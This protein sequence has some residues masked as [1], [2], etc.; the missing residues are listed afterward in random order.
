MNGRIV[1]LIWVIA[2]GLTLAA[3]VAWRASS[4]APSAASSALVHATPI[5]VD[6]VDRVEIRRPGPSR[7]SAPIEVVFERSDEGWRQ[8]EPFEVTADGFAVRRVVLAAA[9]LSATRRN[10]VGDLADGGGLER[11]ELATPD[12]NVTLT[13]PGGRTSIDLGA[14]TV[15]GRA[16]IRIDDRDEVLVVNDALH[17]QAVEDDPRN[18]RSRR[19][20]PGNAEITEFRSANGDS[21]TRL[22][23]D[24]R[25]WLM[26]SPAETRADAAAIDRLVAIVGR[27]EHDGFVTDVPKQLSRYG[28][29][30]PAAIIDVVRDDGQVE[31]LLIGGPAGLVGRGRFAMIDGVPTVF[32]IDEST[33]RGLLPAV[34]SFIDSTGTGVDVA[35]V[36]YL[37][38]DTEQGRVRLDRDLDRWTLSV[39]D[40]PSGPVSGARVEALLAILSSTAAT[41]LQIQAFP[42]R[43]QVGTIVL[44]A[45]DGRPLDAIRIARESA[46]GRWATENGDGVLRL[47]PASTIM[48]LT[49]SAWINAPR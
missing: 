48:P 34:V 37:V 7:E 31:R 6:D 29:E 20:F 18:W 3:R 14:R 39:D 38:I 47:L 28:L 32:R 17:E 24:G 43:L 9:D 1:L 45:F 11:V 2:I 33:L 41:E 10:Q 44:H 25:R 16:W 36:R 15:A 21:V 5:P 23:R 30:D 42:A 19:L 27:I 35:D 49:P 4:E 46:D 26:A 22:L 8:V 40:G 12:S 13:W